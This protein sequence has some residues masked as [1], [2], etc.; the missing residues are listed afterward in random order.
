MAT[1]E[2][3]FL[4]VD[5][6]VPGAG[7]DTVSMLLNRRT[8]IDTGWAAALR[9]MDHG[10][11]P[12][13]LQ[14]L[15]FTH[16]HHDHYI[17]LPQIL[18]HR[19]MIQRR[20]ND[21]RPLY[22]A[23]PAE[24]LAT[25]VQLAKDLLQSERFGHKPNLELRPLLPGDALTTDDFEVT[26][27]R[28]IHPV[29]GLCYRMVDRNSGA[30]IGLT[31][32]TA[33]HPPIA[34]HLTGVDLMVHECSHGPNST[35]DKENTNGH[36]GSPDA[37]EIAKLAGAKRLAMVHTGRANREQ[38]VEA[39]KAIFPNVFYPAPGQTVTVEGS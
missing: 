18:F 24:D 22:I 3:L 27:C 20:T 2:L 6:A 28:T 31:G 17:G 39:A 7:D 1:T 16:L 9:M 21:D 33:Y 32:D 4:G 15:I 30:T 36:S 23:G 8:L 19:W 11:K 34:E 12:T 35:R 25:V 13:D 26:C 29:P 5:S 37:A 38:A 10:V 14:W